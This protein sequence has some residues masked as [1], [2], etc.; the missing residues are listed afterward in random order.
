MEKYSN[1]SQIQSFDQV[2]AIVGWFKMCSQFA[3]IQRV[4]IHFWIMS[5]EAVLTFD[6]QLHQTFFLSQSYRYSEVCAQSG[7]MNTI[8]VNTRTQRIFKQINDLILSQSYRYF[9]VCRQS[10]YYV[11]INH[12]FTQTVVHSWSIQTSDTLMQHILGTWPSYVIPR[13]GEIFSMFVFIYVASM[14]LKS[15]LIKSEPLFGWTDG[16]LSHNM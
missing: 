1:C 12:L 6:S 3:C 15:E 9:V 5:T 7:Y 8:Y 16:W 4:N 2:S 11:T 13:S 14:Y 10:T